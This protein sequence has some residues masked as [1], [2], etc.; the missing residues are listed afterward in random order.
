MRNNLFFINFSRLIISH[1][2][3]KV[4]KKQLRMSTSSSDFCTRNQIEI[5]FFCT[6]FTNVGFECSIIMF[7]FQALEVFHH[8]NLSL[9][10]DVDQQLAV[11]VFQCLRNGWGHKLKWGEAASKIKLGFFK[12]GSHVGLCNFFSIENMMFIVNLKKSSFWTNLY[13]IIH[14][15]RLEKN[16]FLFSQFKFQWLQTLSA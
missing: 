13:A 7:A 8:L 14:D 15:K 5:S 6:T 16:K 1:E 3:W 12:L 9:I 4:I 2:R 10:L 11:M